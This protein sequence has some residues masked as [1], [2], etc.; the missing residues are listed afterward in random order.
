MALDDAFEGQHLHLFGISGRGMAP[1]ALVAQHL[2]ATVTGCDRAPEATRLAQLRR[3]GIPV[4]QQHDEAHVTPRARHIGPASLGLRGERDVSGLVATSVA[5]AS[6]PE[7]SLADDRG[8][9]HHRTDLLAACLRVR[10]GVGVSGSHGKGTVAALTAAALIHAGLDPVTLIGAD[11]PSVGGIARP[12]DGPLVAEVDD[13][14]LTLR[15]V[16]TE[17]AVVTNLDDDHPHLPFTLRETV[18]GVGEFVGR[19]RRR[20]IIGP[21]PR[22][23][24]LAVHAK[25]PV[26]RFGRDFNGRL[27]AATHGRSVITVTAPGIRQDVELRLL[28]ASA[29]A[30]AAV[31]LAAAVS[32]GADPGAAAEGLSR[33]D[34]IHRRLEPVGSRGGIRV[35]DDFG[36]KHP[37]SLRAGIA[38][39]RRHFPE[40]RVTA[41]FEPYGPNLPT[42]GYRYARALS[43]AD[44][45]V[46]APPFL[47]PDYAHAAPPMTRWW[48]ACRTPVIMTSGREAA[49]IEAM[50]HGRP[51]DV[52]VFFA[53]LN[54]SRTMALSAV[55]E[56]TP[57][58]A[59]MAS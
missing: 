27:R 17:V 15:C 47:H 3:A 12:G 13:S 44:R 51:G 55:G 20:V 5:A 18:A 25:V 1:L 33:L 54:S 35:Y 34:R 40:A 41:V 52:V 6:H 36:G 19:A 50:A 45:V 57:G 2:G 59:A 23:A 16:D 29:S 7:I 53:Q 26:W 39:L 42:W 38:A 58:M 4:A 30:N 24:A 48:T 9:L 49:S 28:A 31:A 21:T 37:T 22:A 56:P 32:L 14:D 46:L 11:A 8:I 43:G 10:P